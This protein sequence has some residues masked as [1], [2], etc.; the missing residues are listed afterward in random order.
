MRKE[1]R[2]MRNEICR[3]WSSDMGWELK[4]GNVSV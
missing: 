4:R 2:E 3:I 1:D